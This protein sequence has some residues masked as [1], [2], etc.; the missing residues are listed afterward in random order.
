MTQQ[1]D[2]YDI[3][4]IGGGEIGYALAQALSFDHELSLVDNNPAVSDRFGLLDVQFLTGSGTST[5]VLERA[6]VKGC[7][8]L[9]PCTGLDDW[10]SAHWRP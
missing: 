6:G 1:G 2:F 4:I 5:S 3:I 10:S 8:L 9:I 7:D